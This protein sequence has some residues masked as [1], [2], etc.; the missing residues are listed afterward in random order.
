M[1][2]RRLIAALI[3]LTA[4]LATSGTALAA[5]P[6]TPD[7]GPNVKVFDPS[8]PVS[9]IKA[10]VE[11]IAAHAFE[12]PATPASGSTTSSRCPSRTTGRSTTS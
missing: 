11:A 12:V 4:A 1:R 8:M 3:V 5:P 7:F 6:P 2:L 10:T 9:Q